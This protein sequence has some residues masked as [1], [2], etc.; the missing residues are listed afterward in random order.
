MNGL[1]ILKVQS[2]FANNLG[3]KSFK[4]QSDQSSIVFS[5][6]PKGTVYDF[7]GNPFSG[8]YVILEAERSDGYIVKGKLTLPL[9]LLSDDHKLVLEEILCEEFLRDC[10][11][12]HL[13]PL[14]KECKC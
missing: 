14:F 5:N 13:N 3:W 11:M 10:L 6:D 7:K 12:A 2:L 8:K 9:E 4:V 1:N